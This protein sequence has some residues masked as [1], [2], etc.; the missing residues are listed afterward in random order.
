LLGDELLLRMLP[1]DLVHYMAL[2]YWYKVGGV[3]QGSCATFLGP[4]K[5][6]PKVR[7]QVRPCGSCSN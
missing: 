3:G 1:I 2:T 4:P 5:L 7:A 6:A